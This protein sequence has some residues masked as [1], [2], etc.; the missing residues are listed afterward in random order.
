MEDILA[1]I[2]RIISDDEAP[3]DD[4]PAADGPAARP[5]AGAP[6]GLARAAPAPESDDVLDLTDVFVEDPPDHGT[7]AQEMM[8]QPD[9]M[10]AGRADPDD[11]RDTPPTRA[12]S[13]LS[14]TATAAAR[15]VLGRLSA[16]QASRSDNVALGGA[17]KT[18]EDIVRELLRPMLRDWLDANLPRIVE[19]AV[20][21][22]VERL[23]RGPLD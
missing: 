14:A 13:L 17:G 4:A 15:D 18:L 22:E 12:D 2:R 23:G 6:A 3:A 21:R 19:R 11:D 9:T 5:G 10:P 20:N 16:G 8:E 1:S 7:M